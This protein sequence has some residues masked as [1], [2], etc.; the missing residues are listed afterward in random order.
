LSVGGAR[1]LG[2]LIGLIGFFGTIH[3]FL[4]T[5]DKPSD[6]TIP[7]IAVWLGFF[8]VFVGC[9]LGW[10]KELAASLFI[11]TG[12]AL[13][14]LVALLAPSNFMNAWTLSI[15]SFLGVLFLYVHFTRR[16]YKN[17]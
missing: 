5:I 1:I 4:W 14:A 13:M 6:A 9:V 11:L 16:K 2:S 17:H 10:F 8:L 7:Y 15:P 12:T 3:S